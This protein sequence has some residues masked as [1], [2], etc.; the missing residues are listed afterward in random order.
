MR[1]NQYA[2]HRH[3]EF[4]FKGATGRDFYGPWKPCK[5]NQNSN[6]YQFGF[7]RDLDWS[8]HNVRLALNLDPSKD[9]K[10]NQGNSVDDDR[11]DDEYACIKYIDTTLQ[12]FSNRTLYQEKKAKY[13][14]FINYVDLRLPFLCKKCDVLDIPQG[15]VC[16][17]PV[18][19]IDC[20]SSYDAYPN[21]CRGRR[22]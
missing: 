9:R 15:D 5:Q 22:N 12:S 20:S 13:P 3:N 10:N 14:F 2:S 16:L 19:F 1:Y 6:E 18:N 21:F 17:D 8:A 11:E 4:K 7:F